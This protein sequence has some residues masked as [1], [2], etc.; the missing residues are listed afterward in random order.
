V[1]DFYKKDPK[2]FRSRFLRRCLYGRGI[3]ESKIAPS[4]FVT[5]RDILR[6]SFP[7]KRWVVEGLLSE[8]L[9]L[10]ITS[11]KVGKSALVMGM[12]IDVASGTKAFGNWNT[13]KSQVLLIDLEM[14]IGTEMQGRFKLLGGER[15]GHDIFVVD[16]W[17]RFGDESGIDEIDILLSEH[18]RCSLV[19]VDVFGM[20]KP[21]HGNRKSAAS[22]Y[23]LDYPVLGELR[24]VALRRRACVLVVHHVRKGG[25]ANPIEA[26]SGSSA[27]TGVANTIIMI[28]RNL[29]HKDA[30]VTVTGKGIPEMILPAI[31]DGEKL[32]WRVDRPD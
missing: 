2:T 29:G 22:I 15:A 32:Q 23:D 24:R 21:L 16:E 6:M 18:P 4:K 27:L 25:D 9:A 7:E 8:G 10:L 12:A 14:L 13:R 3:R 19:I 17:P 11:P 31:Y 30:I 20:V 5:V 28:Q 1:N 26:S